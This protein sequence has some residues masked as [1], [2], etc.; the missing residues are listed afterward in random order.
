MQLIHETVDGT[1]RTMT[2]FVNTPSHRQ[3]KAVLRSEPDLDRLYP[4]SLFYTKMK[5]GTVPRSSDWWSSHPQKSQWPVDLGVHTKPHRLHPS[6]LLVAHHLPNDHFS[7]MELLAF[8]VADGGSETLTVEKSTVL[9]QKFVTKIC[10]S[11]KANQIFQ[12]LTKLFATFKIRQLTAL[13][14]YSCYPRTL[15]YASKLP[16]NLCMRNQTTGWSTNFPLNLFTSLEKPN[17]FQ[18]EARP[19]SFATPSQAIGNTSHPHYHRWL[20]QGGLAL[21]AAASAA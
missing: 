6:G 7:P 4:P 12:P 19:A 8:K 2:F 16:E 13:T 1:C 3:F 10:S 20:R 17:T 11:P 15:L 18:V 9:W 5:T 21:A 14:A